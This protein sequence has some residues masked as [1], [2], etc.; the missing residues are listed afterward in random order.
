MTRR[1]V[2]HSTETIDTARRMRDGG[3]TPHEIQQYLT[4]HGT[5]VTFATVKAWVDPAYHSMRNRIHAEDNRRYR[6]VGGDHVKRRMLELSN[7]GLSARAISVVVEIY[8]GRRI[9]QHMVSKFLTAERERAGE[10]V[11]R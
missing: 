9:S 10:E 6:D 5:P 11:S 7:E 4:N 8:H 1:G 2:R 3:W